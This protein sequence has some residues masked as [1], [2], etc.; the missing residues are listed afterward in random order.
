MIP[1]RRVFVATMAS[2][3]LTAACSTAVRSE[4][5]PATNEL[6][7]AVDV[8]TTETSPRA[9]YDAA[10]ALAIRVRQMAEAGELERVDLATIDKIA[11][12]LSDSEDSVREWAALALGQFGPRAERAV[13][14]LE[15]ALARAEK[16]ERQSSRIVLPRTSA[17]SI[18]AAI[19]RIRPSN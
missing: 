13:P 2:A 5:L 8:I 7:R 16:I 1:I 3:V 14:A 4:P 15:L 17:A 18:R 6:A 11:S 19:G 12:L 9:R 10:Q